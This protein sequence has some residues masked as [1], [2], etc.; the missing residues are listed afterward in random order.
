VPHPASGILYVTRSA[1]VEM[2][3]RLAGTRT[4][5]HSDISLVWMQLKLPPLLL[6]E[7]LRPQVKLVPE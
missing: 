4:I 6:Q 1:G 2:I 3:Y 5:I 7:R